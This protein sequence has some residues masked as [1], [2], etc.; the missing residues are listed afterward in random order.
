MTTNS[1]L[2]KYKSLGNN[3]E[4]PE[5][6]ATKVQPYLQR[7]NPVRTPDWGWAIPAEQAIIAEFSPNEDWEVKNIEV[8]ETEQLFYLAKTP[9][10]LILNWDKDLL[11]LKQ[12]TE[13]SKPF[14]EL[15]SSQRE[16]DLYSYTAL[17]RYLLLPV[18]PKEKRVLSQKPFKFAANKTFVKPFQETFSA[19][20]LNYE[21]IAGQEKRQLLALDPTIKFPIHLGLAMFKPTATIEW[22]A[23]S[24]SADKK[25]KALFVRSFAPITSENFAEMTFEP[26]DADYPLIVDAMKE[27]ENWLRPP[28]KQMVAQSVV[29]ES[30]LLR[31]KPE[32]YYLPEDESSEEILY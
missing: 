10:F 32:P 12:V 19:F 25:S 8:G 1:R 27:C 24:Q 23:S 28:V 16:S 30:R 29:L 22:A 2:E 18:C 5:Y 3:I 6:E 4:I 7:I 31:A 9:T 21:I 11:A 13:S 14:L 20:K 17:R 15:F 26:F